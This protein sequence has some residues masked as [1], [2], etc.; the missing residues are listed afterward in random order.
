MFKPSATFHKSP[1]GVITVIVCS[2]DANECLSAYKACQE[3]GEV[4]YFRKGHLD[5][6]KKVDGIVV[7]TKATRKTAKKKKTIYAPSSVV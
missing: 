5:K 7:K 2:E 6:L 3:P 1:T 4:A